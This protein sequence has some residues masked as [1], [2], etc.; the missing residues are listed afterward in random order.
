VVKR[1]DGS[2]YHWVRRWA[3]AQATLCHMG[4]KLPPPTERGTATPHFSTHVYCGQ[5][6]RWIRIPLSRPYRGRPWPRG[7]CVRWG[8]S[9]LPRFSVHFALARSPISATAELLFY[10]AIDLGEH[11]PAMAWPQSAPNTREVGK[12]LRVL[13][14]CLLHSGKKH[15][16]YSRWI[17][18]ACVVSNGDITDDFELS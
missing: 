6:A 16:C 1:L 3:S 13:T 2:R 9:F 12:Y 11:R 8:P 17:G 4:S 14:N 7:H 15:G 10:D 18:V 5:T